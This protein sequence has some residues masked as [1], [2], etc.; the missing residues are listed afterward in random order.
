MQASLEKNNKCLFAA[1]TVYSCCEVIA[2]ACTKSHY[3]I[4]SL[5]S[6]CNPGL[7]GKAVNAVDSS[8][9]LF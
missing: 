5:F 1:V 3:Y 6:L 2:Q 4:L 8:P 9:A 7:F